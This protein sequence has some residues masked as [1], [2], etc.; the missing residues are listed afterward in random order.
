[1]VHKKAK[2]YPYALAD[3]HYQGGVFVVVSVVV[4]EAIDGISLFFFSNVSRRC[5]NQ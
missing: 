2:Q 3:D 4:F 5:T 1:M